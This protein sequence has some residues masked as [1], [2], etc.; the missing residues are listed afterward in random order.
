MITE[1]EYLFLILDT[2]VE[3]YADR[4]VQDELKQ[5]LF[6]HD[7]NFSK[8][9]IIRSRKLLM[10]LQRDVLEKCGFLNFNDINF[11]SSDEDYTDAHYKALKKLSFGLFIIETSATT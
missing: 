1:E 9:F 10:P 2:L 8:G 3:L 4:A 11:P 5:A 7:F 6:D